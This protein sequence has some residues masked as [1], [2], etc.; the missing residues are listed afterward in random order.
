MGRLAVDVTGRGEP[1]VLVH[2]LATTGSIWRRVAPTLARSRSVVAIDVPGFGASDPAGPG[3]KLHAVAQRIRDGLAQAGVPEPYDLVGHSMGGAV[4][5]TLATAYPESVRGLVLVSP[6]G[7]APVPG[8]LAAAVGRAVELYI[9]LRRYG[10]PLA[11]H[12]WGRRLL[13]TGGVIDGAAL[14]PAEVRQLVSSSR[15]A[16]RTRQALVAVAAA[17]LRGMLADL[18]RPVGAIIGT[19]DRV[20]RP[21]TLDTIRALCPDAAC[22]VVTD[23]GHISM[24]ERP[25]QFVTALERVL[26]AIS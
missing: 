6:A 11:G 18:R 16:R 21:G 24:I 19:G 17:D 22:E 23:A 26:V 15:G 12:P 8:P 14:A 20:V 4:A 9:P 1:I 5:L 13:M 25:Q 2:G 10:A 7:L 3:F